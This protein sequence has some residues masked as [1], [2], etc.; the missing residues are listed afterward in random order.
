MIEVPEVDPERIYSPEEEQRLTTQLAELT[1]E[2]HAGSFRRSITLTLVADLHARL[3][4]GVRGHAGRHRR[5][6]RGS[7]RLV[8]G[9]HRSPHRDEVDGQLRTLFERVEH[10]QR[11][12]DANSDQYE[13]DV[14]TLAVWTHAELVRI[15]PF[16]DGNGRTARLVATITL[17]LH[18]LRPVPVEAVKQEYTEALNVYYT[19]HDIEPLRDLYIRLYPVDRGAR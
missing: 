9:P 4:D 12:L 13:L 14:I 15:H 2:A 6:G 19:R 1:A 5:Q 10:L 7:E 8:Y 3:F 18:G 11:R 16:E 17:V